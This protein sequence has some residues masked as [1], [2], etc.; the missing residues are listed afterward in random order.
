MKTWTMAAVLLAGCTLAAC[1][2]ASNPQSSYDPK[3]DGITPSGIDQPVNRSILDNQK[4]AA[5]PA[6]APVEPSTPATAAAPTTPGSATAA[7][8]GTPE[9]PAAP[10]TPAATPATPEKPADAGDNKTSN[11]IEIPDKPVEEAPK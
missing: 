5:A 9:T 8:A 6:A 7:P 1:E 4:L 2:R 10:A 11:P 3:V